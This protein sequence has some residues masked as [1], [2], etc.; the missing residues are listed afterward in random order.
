[1]NSHMNLLNLNQLEKSFAFSQQRIHVELNEEF[2]R[3][4]KSHKSICTVH[5][6]HNFPL[7]IYID[8]PRIRTL[9]IDKHDGDSKKVTLYEFVP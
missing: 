1:M 3:I 2:K 5:K 4:E 6:N 8:I 7:C 9:F